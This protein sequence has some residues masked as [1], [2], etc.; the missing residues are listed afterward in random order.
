MQFQ[1][2]D[3]AAVDFASSLY[4]NMSVDVP[5]DLAVSRARGR[6]SA[7]QETLEWATPVLYLASDDT[8]LFD[9]SGTEEVGSEGA[10]RAERQRLAEETAAKE[11]A[12]SEADDAAARASPWVDDALSKAE[13]ERIADE[14]AREQ[15]QR[16]EREAAAKTEQQ[17]IKDENARAEQQRVKDAATARVR[18]EE[19]E[20]EAAARADERRIADERAMAE[21][22]RTLGDQNRRAAESMHKWDKYLGHETPEPQKPPAGKLEWLWQIVSVVLVLFMFL[23]LGFDIWGVGHSVLDAFRR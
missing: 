7:K 20:A 2:T 3:S 1:I 5:I 16:L 11:Q 6:I 14:T 4:R 10:M 21:F 9:V 18:R 12:H 13:Q 19:L 22:Q 23:V 8:S 17:R 15:W